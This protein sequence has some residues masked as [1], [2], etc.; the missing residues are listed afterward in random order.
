MFALENTQRKRHGLVDLANQLCL[1]D[2]LGRK[3]SLRVAC[4]KSLVPKLHQ[5]MM[6]GYLIA[7]TAPTLDLFENYFL[8]FKTIKKP[9]FCF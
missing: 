2:G 6:Q 5:S 1:R 3:P 4:S 7:Q 8:F 9:V